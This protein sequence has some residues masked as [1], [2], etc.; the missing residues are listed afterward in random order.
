MN[1]TDEAKCTICGHALPHGGGMTKPLGILGAIYPI[2]ATNIYATCHECPGGKCQAP[3]PD[4]SVVL[5]GFSPI[6]D[7]T[8]KDMID[9]LIA[10]QRMQLEKL[11]TDRIIR[12]M[13]NV[14]VFEYANRV[15]AEAGIC[16]TDGDSGTGLIPVE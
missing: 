1:P 11:D 15:K 12:L 6:R 5:L 10:F 2:E 8:R 4:K 9:E 16:E 14:R 7:M 3:R 13:V